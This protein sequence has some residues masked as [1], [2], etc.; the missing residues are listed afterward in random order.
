MKKTSVDLSGLPHGVP[1]VLVVFGDKSGFVRVQ[2]ISYNSPLDILDDGWVQ[3][4]TDRESRIEAATQAINYYLDP[5]ASED[6]IDA[7]EV[8][9][10]D[11]GLTYCDVCEIRH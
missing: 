8:E 9:E 1:L 2:D 7:L 11:D 10:E 3:F 4:G 6:L 5:Y